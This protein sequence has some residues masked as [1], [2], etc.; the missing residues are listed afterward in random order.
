MFSIQGASWP[1]S[2]IN[3]SGNVDVR[4][5]VQKLY[6]DFKDPMPGIIFVLPSSSNIHLNLKFSPISNNMAS[7]LLI[8]RNNLT[9]I[10][11]VLM[12]G[13]AGTGQ[14][15]VGNGGKFHPLF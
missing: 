1:S 12:K 10:E 3:G 6:P 2:Q 8:L 14:L 11:G 4:K 7:T 9:G 13:R 5:I 15:T